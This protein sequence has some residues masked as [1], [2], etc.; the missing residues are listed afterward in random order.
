VELGADLSGEH[1]RACR[2]AVRHCEKTHRRMGGSKRRPQR[3]DA[4]GTDDCY[5]KIDALHRSNS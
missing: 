3:A 5:A 2:I 4:T 1:L